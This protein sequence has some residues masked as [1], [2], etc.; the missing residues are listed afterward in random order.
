MKKIVTIV[1]IAMCIC[2][3]CG[4]LVIGAPEPVEPLLSNQAP[5]APLV[6]IE[7]SNTNTDCYLQTFHSEDPDGDNIYYEITWTKLSTKEMNTASPDEPIEPWLGP[8]SSGEI[9]ETIHTCYESGEY[10][11]SI[12]AKDTHENIGLPTTVHITHEDSMNLYENFLSLLQEKYP[13][14]YS[15]LEKIF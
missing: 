7:I 15:I 8:Y 9:I 14:I 13:T 2:L 1:L 12:R 4:S 11:I 3:G 6:S 5:T 10:E